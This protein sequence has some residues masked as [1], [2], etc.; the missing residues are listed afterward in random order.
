LVRTQA[1]LQVVGF[2]CLLR[3]NDVNKREKHLLLPFASV[4]ARYA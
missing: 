2:G 1:P 4:S 3:E